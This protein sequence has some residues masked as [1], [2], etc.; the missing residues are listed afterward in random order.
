VEELPGPPNPHG[1]HRRWG[2]GRERRVALGHTT[3]VLPWPSF[4]G[5]DD[6]MVA[7]R[8]ADRDADVSMGALT[9][10]TLS[11]QAPFQSDRGGIDADVSGL[12][13]RPDLLV[14]GSPGVGGLLLL[15]AR[16]VPSVQRMELV[17]RDVGLG[18]WS[19]PELESTTPPTSPTSSFDSW[20]TPS[21]LVGGPKGE[22]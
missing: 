20:A 1:S 19:E 12:A 5:A 4:L 10:T 15:R 11:G 22:F 7:S 14:G 6:L 17:G 13:V 3:S 21:G 16:S 18:S 9:P 2:G 8:Q